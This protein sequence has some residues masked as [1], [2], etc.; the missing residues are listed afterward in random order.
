[1]NG[2][3]YEKLG[4]SGSADSRSNLDLGD[5]SIAGMPLCCKVP[6]YNVHRLVEYAEPVEEG[7]A[8]SSAIFPF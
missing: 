1:M 5:M 2:R 3:P 6:H 4:A 8:W 7:L